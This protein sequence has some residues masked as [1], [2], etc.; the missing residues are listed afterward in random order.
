MSSHFNPNTRISRKNSAPI[1]IV[2]RVFVAIIILVLFFIGAKFISRTAS[3]VTTSASDLIAQTINMATPK[4]VLIARQNALQLQNEQLQQQ[5]LGMQLTEDE[6]NSLRTILNYPKIASVAMPA[7]VISKPSSNIYDRIIIDQGSSNGVTVGD[8]II[9][10]ENSYLA[11]IDT[12]TE[13]TAE[14]TLVS[15]SFFA[16]DAII[17][18]LGITVP[19]EGKGSGNF[20]LHVPRDLDVREN[21]VMT[22]PGSPD[23]IFGVIKSVQFDERDPYQTVLARTP[24]NV[25]ELKFV[26]VI[27]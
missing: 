16:G 17:T 6:N 1:G 3:S 15:G 24:I 18:R 20:E 19:V 5:L 10:G 22:L 9:A 23:F 11:T 2:V 26:R 8:K 21:D 12:V 13:T 4:S 14:G 27:K 7:R 25:Q